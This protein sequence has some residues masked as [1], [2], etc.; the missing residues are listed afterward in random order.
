MSR[1]D[2]A[3]VPRRPPDAISKVAPAA[4]LDELDRPQR[5]R[6][7]YAIQCDVVAKEAERLLGGTGWPPEHARLWCAKISMPLSSL[8]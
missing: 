7:I 1:C 8:S 2:P 5:L 4:L 6:T 3:R